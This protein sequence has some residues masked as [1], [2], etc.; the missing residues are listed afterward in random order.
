MQFAFV[1]LGLEPVVIKIDLKY[2]VGVWLVVL[3][4]YLS[5]PGHL[6]L[7]LNKA[8]DVG[9]D[10]FELADEVV[11]MVALEDAVDDA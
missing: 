3:H 5:V 7:L 10:A 2:V 11:L 6:Q 9:D 4:E 8:V 1:I